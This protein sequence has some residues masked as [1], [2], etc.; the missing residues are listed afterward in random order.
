[1]LP[2]QDM[3]NAVRRQR[4]LPASVKRLTE[5]RNPMGSISST[6]SWAK[7][8][9]GGELP[10]IRASGKRKGDASELGNCTHLFVV[11]HLS[12]ANVC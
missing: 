7:A 3:A 10:R 11:N 4:C 12:T 1:M 5:S 2:V 8:T 9:A 6:Y